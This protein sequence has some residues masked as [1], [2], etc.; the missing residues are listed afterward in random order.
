MLKEIGCLNS[1]MYA[2]SDL[3]NLSPV[4]LADDDGNGMVVVVV[5]VEGWGVRGPGGGGEGRSK[6][7]ILSVRDG[8]F[9]SLRS[10][11]HFPTDCRRLAV[12]LKFLH[13]H[14]FSSNNY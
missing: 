4:T 5:V 7:S 2:C 11:T 3:A 6:R 13:F 1:G 12:D 10:D 9:S 14:N 8:R